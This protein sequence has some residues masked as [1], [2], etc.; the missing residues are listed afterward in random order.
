MT[1]NSKREADKQEP[2]TQSIQQLA[3]WAKRRPIMPGSQHHLDCKA[4]IAGDQSACNCCDLT[5]PDDDYYL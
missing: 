1:A 3:A 4:L 2:S 5:F